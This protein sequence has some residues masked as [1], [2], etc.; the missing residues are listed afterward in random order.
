MK[1]LS[2]KERRVCVRVC[3]YMCVHHAICSDYNTKIEKEKREYDKQHG[4]IRTE[5]TG[6]E[7]AEEME[8]ERHCLQLQMCELRTK[9]P[10]A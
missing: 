5:V 6:A 2:L 8:P 1:Q 9:N 4:M 3:A 10:F 7:I